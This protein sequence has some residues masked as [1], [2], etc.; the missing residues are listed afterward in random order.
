M[1]KAF[2][3]NSK[4]LKEMFFSVYSLACVQK[5][6]GD[7][8]RIKNFDYLT[9]SLIEYNSKTLLPFFVALGKNNGF[10]EATYI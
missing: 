7:A 5:L 1:K 9:K 2:G 8:L 3:S 4:P 6:N 10:K